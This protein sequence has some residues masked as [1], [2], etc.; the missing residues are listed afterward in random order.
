MKKRTL[1]IVD[2]DLGF[3]MALRDH[4]EQKG[5]MDI[6]TAVTG[7]EGIQ[8]CGKRVI[9][10][11]ILDQKL[12]DVDGDTLC[13]DILARNDKT[14]IIFCTAF[15]SFESAERALEA[16]AFWYVSKPVDLRELT[17][18]VNKGLRELELEKELE[19]LSDAREKELASLEFIG[20]SE[21]KREIDRLMGLAAATDS[22]VLITGETGTGKTFVARLIHKLSGRKGPFVS[23][24]CAALP[25]N[26]IEEE[27]FGHKKGA[28]TGA[29]KDKR[30][31][32]EVADEGTLF[33]DEIGDMP[34]LLQSKLLSVID[35]KKIRRIGDVVYRNTGTRIIAATN[36]DIDQKASTGTFRKDLY[37]RLNVIRIH[38]PPLRDRKDDI[39]EIATYFIKKMSNGKPYRIS[40]EELQGLCAYAWEGNIR[41]LRN[42]IERAIIISN[43]YNVQPSKL[44]DVSSTRRKPEVMF[45]VAPETVIPLKDL[46]RDYILKVLDSN[47][48]N[49][50]KTARDL[51]MSLSTLKRRLKSFG[52]FRDGSK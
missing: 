43:G 7:R 18:A 16:G 21:L 6:F 40:E 9:D 52:R 29:V 44:L 32:F 36:S 14:K 41:E 51:G 15:P 34:L 17:F 8:L 38:L 20:S 46:E 47:E 10:V 3:S 27:L 37:Y 35:E 26:L 23:I 48:G 33:L 25:E 30:G 50:S 1:L 39:P 24:N 19:D 42:V 5:N 49:I 2:D 45:P 28:F 13:P 11:V 4:F 22:P 12:P 31:L